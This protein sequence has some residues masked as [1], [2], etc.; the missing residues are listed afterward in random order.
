MSAWIENTA[1]WLVSNN[2]QVPLFVLLILMVFA[3][4]AAFLG[5]V[6]PGETALITG[7]LLAFEGVWPLWLFVIC[8]IVAAITGDSIGYFI[9][10]KYGERI[11]SAQLGR[12]VGERDGVL[13]NTFLIDTTGERFSLAVHKAFCGR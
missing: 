5:L 13:L 2:L 9:G 4:G 1:E 12:F 3:E 7:G 8:S 6:L 11:K 10:H